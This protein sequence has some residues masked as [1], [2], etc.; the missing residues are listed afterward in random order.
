MILSKNDVL[1]KSYRSKLSKLKW[2]PLLGALSFAFAISMFL[3]PIGVESV[4]AVV[5]SVGQKTYSG[6][7]VNF[8]MVEFKVAHESPRLVKV[9]VPYS[10]TLKP[11]DQ[12]KIDRSHKLIPGFHDYRY[13]QLISP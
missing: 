8:A 7:A 3:I 6:G 2:S 11:G 1:S 10:V 5:K 4:D 9:W 13:G 12:V